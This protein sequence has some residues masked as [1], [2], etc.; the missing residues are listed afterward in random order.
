MVHALTWCSQALIPTSWR[1]YLSE[2]PHP[3]QLHCFF[4][5]SDTVIS[6]LLYFCTFPTGPL[7]F[8][9]AL[10]VIL[11]TIAEGIIP[12]C[13]SYH[14]ISLLKTFQWLLITECKHLCSAHW[15]LAIWPMLLILTSSPI[16][17]CFS[18]SE[19]SMQILE[20][21]IS[22]HVGAYYPLPEMFSF[23]IFSNSY[24]SFRNS[25]HGTIP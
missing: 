8:Q 21:L 5:P 17:P 13:K 19:L 25:S 6:P 3:L 16:F 18:H 23:H 4:P 9:D 7:A 15:T 24:S 12:E 1:P 14:V 22:L 20:S 2:L 11:H 10:W